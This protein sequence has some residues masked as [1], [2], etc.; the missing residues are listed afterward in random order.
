MMRNRPTLDLHIPEPVARPGDQ[1]SLTGMVL[2]APGETRRPD[3]LA[4]EA[5]MRDLPYGLI[6]VL[7]DAGLPIGPW[8]PRI[9]PDLLR[10]GLRAMMLTQDRR[11]HV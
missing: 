1:T 6:R 5:D 11:A 8:A 3:S 4:A 2:P 10:H 7:N 9:T